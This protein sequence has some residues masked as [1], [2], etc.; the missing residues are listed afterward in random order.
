MKSTLFAMAAALVMTGSGTAFAAQ[1]GNGPA[2]W[3]GQVARPI[4]SSV[5]TTETGSAAYPSFNSASTRVVSVLPSADTNSAAYPL[6]NGQVA[7][8]GPTANGATAVA[9]GTAGAHPNS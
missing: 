2:Y 5:P 6:L 9:S 1:N 7:S 3:V 8:V 4:Y